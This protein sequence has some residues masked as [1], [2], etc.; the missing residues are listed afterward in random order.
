MQSEARRKAAKAARGSKTST[1][2]GELSRKKKRA[3]PEYQISQK[4][5]HTSHP[6]MPSA[7]SELNCFTVFVMI[8]K[9]VN[10]LVGQVFL[11][12]KKMRIYTAIEDHVDEKMVCRTLTPGTQT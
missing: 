2:R 4:S 10:S 9:G 7:C 8:I 1:R 6:L 3:R 5:R 11:I 12:S